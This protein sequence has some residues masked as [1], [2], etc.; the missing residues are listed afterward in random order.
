MRA[1]SRINEER[2]AKMSAMFEEL[3]VFF[4]FSNEQFAK[5]S[6]KDVS[7]AS[8]GGGMFVPRENAKLVLQRFDNIHNETVQKFK[9][10]VSSDDYILYELH[11]H[12]CFYT[13]DYPEIL[14]VVQSYYSD[15]TLEDIRKVYHANFK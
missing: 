12:E 14:E 2:K 5:N 3:G 7:Y 8:M 4:A 1:I 11:N 6:K 13:G 10:Q 9:E 15:C